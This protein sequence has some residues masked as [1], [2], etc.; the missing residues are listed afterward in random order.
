M[1]QAK[2][3]KDGFFPLLRNSWTGWRHRL[4]VK[5][6]LKKLILHTMGPLKL[7]WA[8][9]LKWEHPCGFSVAHKMRVLFLNLALG[10]KCCNNVVGFFFVFFLLFC[11]KRIWTT[12]LCFECTVGREFS[13]FWLHRAIEHSAVP[14]GMRRPPAGLSPLSLFSVFTDR[15]VL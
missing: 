9:P 4:F 12:R 3:A 7:F 5:I 8:K 6:S 1:E 15:D 11:L 10:E 14:L 13:T 2:E